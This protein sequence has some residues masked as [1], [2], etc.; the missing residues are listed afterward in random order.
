MLNLTPHPIII[1]RKD[2]DVITILTSGTV[3]RVQ[4]KEEVVGELDGIPVVTRTFGAPEGLPEDGTP[5]LVSSLVLGACQGKAGV[6][7]PDTGPSA[8]RDENGHILA[9]TRLVK[10]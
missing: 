7:A 10:A 9:V 5:C 2:G 1:R 4:T 3:A 8:I 6:Y